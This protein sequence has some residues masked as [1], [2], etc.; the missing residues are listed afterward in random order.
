MVKSMGSGT[1][2]R[3]LSHVT[4]SKFLKQLDPQCLYTKKMEENNVCITLHFLRGL[5]N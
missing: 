5:I 3:I 1:C 2:F 4:L